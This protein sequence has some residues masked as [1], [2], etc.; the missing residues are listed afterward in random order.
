MRELEKRPSPREVVHGRDRGDQDVQALLQERLA[1]GGPHGVEAHVVPDVADEQQRPPGEHHLGAVDAGVGAVAVH[2]AR[3]RLPALGEGRLQLTGHQAEPAAVAAD[4]VRAVDGGHGVLQ[5][6][7][8]GDRRLQHDVRDVRVVLAADPVPG[9][10]RQLDVQAVAAQ[11]HRLRHAGIAAVA[12]ELARVGQPDGPVT[13]LRG[14][15]PA[16]DAVV[17]DVGVGGAL[18]REVRVEQPVRLRDHLRTAPLV[19]AA[20]ELVLQRQGVRPVERVEQ[21]PPAGVRGVQRVP[22]D[23]R[24]HHEL[25]ARHLGDLPVHAGDGDRAAPP[26]AAGSRSR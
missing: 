9:V 25:R 20:G 13:R 19:V 23:R 26:G 3:D 2:G 10:D 18:E 1:A 22:R 7:D 21:R 11:Q 17:R 8:R 12:D 4:L 5:V 15:C 16:V 24:R 6:D 14:Q